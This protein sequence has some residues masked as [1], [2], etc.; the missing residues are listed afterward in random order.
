MTTMLG[1]LR[2]STE[3]QANSGLGLDAKRDPIRRYA[4]AK[5]WSIQWYEDA[6]LSAKSLDR[7]QLQAALTR[8]HA[9]VSSR[10]V[11]GLA[12]A[13][14]DRLSRSVVDFASVLHLPAPGSGRS[15]PS[16]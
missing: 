12:V 11:D 8:L 14:F 3:E 15:S 9:S 7:P 1:C 5:G 10:G 6:G 16:T 2:V 4:D 13:K